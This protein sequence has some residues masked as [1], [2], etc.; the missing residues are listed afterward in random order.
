M[1]RAQHPRECSTLSLSNKIHKVT[2]EKICYG[3]VAGVLG[4]DNVRFTAPVKPGDTIQVRTN[5]INKREIKSRPDRGLISLR[6]EVCNQK[7]E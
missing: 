3:T 4:F 6:H 2:D 5:I 7:S 1:R